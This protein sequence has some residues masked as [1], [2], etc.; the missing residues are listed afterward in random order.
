NNLGHATVSGSSFSIALNLPA[1]SN[2][3]EFTD[4]D[5]SGNTSAPATFTASIDL[6]PPQVS[7]IA[8]PSPRT[9]NS[10]VDSIDVTFSKAIDS[11]TFSVADLTLTDNGMGV[12]ITSAVTISLVSG[13]TYR[14]AGLS[15]L[16]AAEGSYVL[17]VNGTNIH[18]L[19]GNAG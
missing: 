8:A 12:P 15:G 4:M 10:P 19:A 6:T 5:A 1:G 3:L 18:D 7:S 13:S 14:I 17:T 9:R 16:T 11:S 2:V